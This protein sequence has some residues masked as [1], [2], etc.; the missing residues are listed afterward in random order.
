MSA[1]IN[2]LKKRTDKFT[3]SE[4]WGEKAK[5]IEEYDK[6]LLYCLRIHYTRLFV[7]DCMEKSL[8]VGAL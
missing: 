6:D 7:I 5:E 3:Y 4:L 1:S 2:L 8:K